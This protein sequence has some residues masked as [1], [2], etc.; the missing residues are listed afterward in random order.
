VAQITPPIEATENGEDFS[1]DA[2]PLQRRARFSLWNRLAVEDGEVF[3]VE[4]SRCRE[5][6]GFLGGC[7]PAVENGEDFSV[8]ALPL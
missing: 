2:P 6:R 8:D 5:R 4:S 7:P 3:S 1:V